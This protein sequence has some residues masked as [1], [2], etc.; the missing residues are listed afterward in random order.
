MPV[1]SLTDEQTRRFGSTVNRSDNNVSTTQERL[2]ILGDDEIDELYARP[3]F[4]PD[5]L[6]QF[7]SLSQPEK[8]LLQELRSV[9]SQAYFVLQLGYFKAKH[10]FFNFDFDSIFNCFFDNVL[11]SFFGNFENVFIGQWLRSDQC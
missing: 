1:D 9:K 10:L 11:I 2:R 7:F 8:D 5:E 4:T 6:T 3:T